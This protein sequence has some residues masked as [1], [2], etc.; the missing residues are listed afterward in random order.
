MFCKIFCE[1]LF[2]N[3]PDHMLDINVGLICRSAVN[4]AMHSLIRRRYNKKIMDKH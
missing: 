3:C 4:A 2:S 1:I